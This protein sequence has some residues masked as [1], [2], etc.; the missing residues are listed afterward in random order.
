MWRRNDQLSR[1][2]FNTVASAMRL[3]KGSTVL[4][5]TDLIIDEELF[6]RGMITAECASL[7]SPGGLSCKRTL[8]FCCNLLTVYTS[9]GHGGIG[10]ANM[11]NL[12]NPLEL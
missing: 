6:E 7:T 8:S 2:L 4:R 9:D 5:Q 12:S 3:G 1:G 11:V 10:S